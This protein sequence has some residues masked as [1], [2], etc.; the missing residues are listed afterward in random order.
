M[1]NKRG[2]IRKKCAAIKL[3][4]VVPAV[5]L[6][7]GGCVSLKAPGE[8]LPEETLKDFGEAL[9]ALDADGML[10][11]MDE[12][13]KKSITASMN[14]AMGLLGALTDIS[15]GF[16]AED[17][18]A[19]LPL[20][21]RFIPMDSGDYPS[22]DFQATQTYISGDKATVYFYE[23]NSGDSSVV[24]MVKED[25][26]W[27]LTLD[28]RYIDESGADR[29]IIAGEE[30]TQEAKASEDEKRADLEKRIGALA[31]FFGF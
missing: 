7:L 6:S 24:N 4:I 30:Q 15:L 14:I 1:R 26:Q 19:A 10:E 9:N 21:Q 5:I 12:K 2:W 25:G 8:P 22:V 28:N 13:T 29:I 18:L 23:V 20:F 27:K 3:W 16:D 17:L 11:C 31:E